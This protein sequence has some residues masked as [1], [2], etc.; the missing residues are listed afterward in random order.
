MADPGLISGA[1]LAMPPALPAGTRSSWPSLVPT[2]TRTPGLSMTSIFFV[3]AP[4][5]PRARERD[6]VFRARGSRQPR[7][8]VAAVDQHAAGLIRAVHVGHRADLG[9]L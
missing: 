8:V 6:F 3:G 4:A 9:A 7:Q 5:P 2:P 1:H